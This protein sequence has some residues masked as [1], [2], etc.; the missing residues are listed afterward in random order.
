M[1]VQGCLKCECVP[2]PDLDD[3]TE[4]SECELLTRRQRLKQ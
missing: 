3:A 4:V 1:A 2:V